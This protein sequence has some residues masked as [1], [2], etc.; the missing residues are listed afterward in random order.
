MREILDVVECRCHKFIDCVGAHAALSRVFS[1]VPNI[2]YD[3]IESG[4]AS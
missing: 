3:A 2:A 1:S 4:E